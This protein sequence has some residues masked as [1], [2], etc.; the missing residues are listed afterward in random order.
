MHRVVLK[1]HFQAVFEMVF[2]DIKVVGVTQCN[3]SRPSFGAGISQVKMQSRR[4]CRVPRRQPQSPARKGCD[5]A[6]HKTRR[7]V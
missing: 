5:L 3:G 2:G 4:D 7:W 6:K 1:S